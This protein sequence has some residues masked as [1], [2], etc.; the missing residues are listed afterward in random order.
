MTLRAFDLGVMSII[1]SQIKVRETNVSH[2][3]TKRRDTQK[4]WMEHFY[5]L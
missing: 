3:T 1:R 4:K 2:T 5:K